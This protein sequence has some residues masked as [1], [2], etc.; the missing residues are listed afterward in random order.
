M[1]DVKLKPHTGNIHR[2][3]PVH[4]YL[5]L[6]RCEVVGVA[7]TKLS[8]GKPLKAKELNVKLKCIEFAFGRNNILYESTQVLW[9]SNSPSKYTHLAEIQKD[10]KLKVPLNNTLPSS[11]NLQNYRIV[12]KLEANLIHENLTFVG[13]TKTSSVILQLNRYSP[14]YKQLTTYS[15]R[16]DQLDYRT[17]FSGRQSTY[18]SSDNLFASINLT[19]LSNKISVKKLAMSLDRRVQFK[20]QKSSLFRSN[21]QLTRIVEE[22]VTPQLQLQQPQSFN[23]KGVIPKSKSSLSW[24]IGESLLTTLI[25]MQFF[26]TFTALIKNSSGS[27]S[28]IAL[29][30]KEITLLSITKEEL[31]YAL[32]TTSRPRSNHISSVQ[33]IAL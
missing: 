3:F 2:Q 32:E 9:S 14:L 30:S 10:F 27:T 12:W 23:F 22:V 13:N 19:L 21:V 33:T 20:A 18:K 8:D 25:D 7:Y 5:G 29:D 6:T 24:S 11:I 31:H 28:S 15:Q 1:L 17:Y 4:G 26:I 16:V